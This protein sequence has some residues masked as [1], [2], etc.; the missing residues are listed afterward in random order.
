VRIRS[1]HPHWGAKKLADLVQRKFGA[2]AISTRT[3]ARILVRAGLVQR[4]RRRQRSTCVHVGAPNVQPKRP[5]DLW[6]VDFKGWWLTKAGERCEPLTVRDAFSRYV[7]AID[8]LQSTEQGP[9]EATFK[10]LFKAHGLPKAIHTDGG[11]PFVATSGKLGLSRLNV[12]WLG[13]GIEHYRSRPA[14]PS[15]NGGHERLHKDM[16]A[17]LE[18]FAALNRKTQ[19]DACD[20]WRHEFN[21]HR[22]HEALQMRMPGEVYRRSDVEF[23]DKPVEVTYPEN[24]LVRLVGSTG[25]ATW[26]HRDFFVSSALGK[27][28]IGLEPLTRQTFNVWFAHRW[29]GVVDFKSDP[30]TFTAAPWNTVPS[31]NNA[32]DES[33]VA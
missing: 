32:A 26:R 2:D 19:Q 7:L 33:R 23:E 10:R 15:D 4:A 14:T 16:A 24:Y 3:V 20:R 31:S 17:E 1:A 11:T 22:P 28:L 18:A 5:N 8:V 27:Q 29:L 21:H 13:L 9:V 25:L 30:P 6:T 12:W